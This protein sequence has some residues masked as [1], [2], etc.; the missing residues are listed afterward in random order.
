MCYLLRDIAVLQG[1]L[2]DAGTGDYS[3]YLVP[4]LGGNPAHRDVPAALASAIIE[5]AAAA[6]RK[7]PSQTKALVAG[8]GSRGGKL[9]ERIAMRVVASS[10]EEASE[11]AYAYLS[12]E[13]I[14]DAARRNGS[15]SRSRRSRSRFGRWSRR[16]ASDSWT[17]PRAVWC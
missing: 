4:D 10:P 11:I 5:A 2:D 7:D 1:R 17:E 3:H 8:I 9:F 16:S 6:I 12:D 13:T 15:A 14:I